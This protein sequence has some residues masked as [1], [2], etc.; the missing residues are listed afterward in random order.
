M[1]ICK[2]QEI[3]PSI[4]FWN[5]LFCLNSVEQRDSSIFSDIKWRKSTGEK[6]KKIKV[7]HHKQINLRLNSCTDFFLSTI[8]LWHYLVRH[9]P[10]TVFFTRQN[11]PVLHKNK[12]DSLSRSSTTVWENL[13]QFIL[14]LD[15]YPSH[16]I[17]LERHLIGP[18]FILQ[19]CNNHKH[20]ARVI[21]NYLQWQE[22]MVEPAALV[23]TLWSLSRITWRDRRHRESLRS[24]ENCGTLSDMLP[25]AYLPSKTCAW[26]SRG[27]V[28]FS[29]Q[30]VVTLNIHLVYIL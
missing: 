16:T 29:G 26:A 9:F 4:K 30:R 18:K 23:S 25:T 8:P 6:S 22:Q 17:P 14:C 12:S 21:K 19:Q 10:L 15:S 20:A 28:L 5:C 3:K 24:Q 1:N 11:H 2:G 13:R 7:K 27:P